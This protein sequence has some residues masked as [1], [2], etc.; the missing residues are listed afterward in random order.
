MR[1]AVMCRRLQRVPEADIAALL[2]HAR[3]LTMGTY[4]GPLGLK[5]LAAIVGKIEY[6]GLRLPK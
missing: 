5:R 1:E 6:P 3:G 2:G 4:A